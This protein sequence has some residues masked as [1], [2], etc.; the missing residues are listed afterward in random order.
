MRRGAALPLLNGISGAPR[1][2]VCVIARTCASDPEL[3]A[4][5]RGRARTVSRETATALDVRHLI[6]QTSC[7]MTFST[8][9]AVLAQLANAMAAKP[10]GEI[11][12]TLTFAQSL[13]GSIAAANRKPMQLSSHDSWVA[14]HAMRAM[15]NAI[16]V[17]CG[18]V[19]AD[20]P[21]LTT[22]LVDG[23]SPRPVVFDTLL[24][25]PSTSAL[26]KARG[27]MAEGAILICSDGPMDDAMRARKAALESAGAVICPC[28]SAHG[29]RAALERVHERFRLK[30]FMVEG[31]AKLITS[32]LQCTPPVD[33]VVLTVA[34][35]MAGGLVCLTSELRVKLEFTAVALCGGDLLLDCIVLKE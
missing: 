29:L 12:V 5:S 32:A 18:T 25:I 16:V 9:H 30:S 26:I 35:Q 33:R 1:V 28:P 14:T 23:P 34:P 11:F 17:G 2:L 6:V 19:I 22:R 24:R 21:S 7:D 10:Q 27:S 31:G 4:S 20:N 15:H 3:F 8:P 13:D